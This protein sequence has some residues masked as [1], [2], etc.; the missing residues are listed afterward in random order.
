MIAAL[1]LE[2]VRRTR[3]SIFAPLAKPPAIQIFE[4][5]DNSDAVAAC[6]FV[7][8][9]SLTQVTPSFVRTVCKR[10]LSSSNFAIPD[11]TNGWAIPIASAKPAAAIA[12]ETLCGTAG[13]TSFNSA[14][15]SAD[16][17]EDTKARSIRSSSTRPISPV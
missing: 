16:S 2:A 9:E 10:C 13:F 1:I 7:A 4:R 14:I 5:C 12:F 11:F 15:T 17:G 6:G 3:S 8:L